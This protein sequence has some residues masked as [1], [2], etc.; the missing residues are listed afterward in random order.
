[1]NSEQHHPTHLLPVIERHSF[2]KRGIPDS[3]FL[4][5]LY[6]FCC[7]VSSRAW[8]VATPGL[9]RHLGNAFTVQ[10]RVDV[11]MWSRGGVE[12]M[13]LFSRHLCCLGPCLS[14]CGREVSGPAWVVAAV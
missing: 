6:C 8:L 5:P 11:D 4:G 13:A 3:L 10:W 2:K 14:G 7:P 12:E 9:D 1:M